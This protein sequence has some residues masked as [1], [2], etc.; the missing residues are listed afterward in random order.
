MITQR[1]KITGVSNNLV[2]SF[3]IREEFSVF[4][5]YFMADKYH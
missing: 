5:K 2:S 4:L 1:Q 3:Q